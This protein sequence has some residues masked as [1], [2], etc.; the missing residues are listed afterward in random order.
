MNPFIQSYDKSQKKSAGKGKRKL[1][2][3]DNDYS[4]YDSNYSNSYQIVALKPKR[5]K[6]GIPTTEVIGETNVNGKKTLLRILI[7]TGS[8]SSIILNKFIDKNTLVKNKKI[9]T[10]WTTL[11][12][13]LYAKKQG[14]VRFKIPELFLNKTTEFKLH[15]DE[16]TVQADASYDMII[17]RNLITELKLV[18]DFDTQCITWDGIAQ[19]MTIQGGLQKET[20]Y[21]EILSALMDSGSTVFQV[22]YAKASE[23]EHV[24]AAKKRQTRILDANYEAADLKEIIKSISTI[25]EI[26]RNKLLLLLRKYEHLFHG[27]LRDFETSEVKF[28][29]KENVK[30][31]HA[32][33]FK[34]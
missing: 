31:Y 13:K 23:P 18:L 20:T 15:A 28:D 17:G 30:P 19:P 7:D 34:T 29:F 6:I 9:A 8:S 14:T 2:D 21:Y 25:N 5:S 33:A 11:G 12:E 22:D 27:T 10:E 3:S 26:E 1:S 16:T 32:K 24:H 4:D